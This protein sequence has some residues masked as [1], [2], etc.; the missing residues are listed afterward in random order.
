MECVW[1]VWTGDYFLGYGVFQKM[2]SKR[3][4]K[5]SRPGKAPRDHLLP[6]VPPP[7]NARPRPY[8]FVPKS[9]YYLKF[10]QM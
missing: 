1:C 10:S 8:P 3:Y 6:L 7:G 9:Y 5:S 2:A 4:Y